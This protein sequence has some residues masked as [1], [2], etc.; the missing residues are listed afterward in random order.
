VGGWRGYQWEVLS[1]GMPLI[2]ALFD[3]RVLDDG[4]GPHLYANVRLRFHPGDWSIFKWDG[5]QWNRMPQGF[6][7]EP[8]VLGASFDDGTGLA[9]Y[10]SFYDWSVE[11]GTVERWT[12]SSW[13]PVGQTDRWAAEQYVVYD[14]GS[15]PSL[16]V[17]GPFNAIGGVPARRIARWDGAMWHALGAG[18]VGVR[19]CRKLAVIEDGPGAG[20]YFLG[21]V[22]VSSPN[23]LQKWDGQS[24]TVIPGPTGP[25]N[26]VFTATEMI[27]FDDGRGPAI[28]LGGSFPQIGGLQANGLARW[29]GVEWSL[30]GTGIGWGGVSSFGVFEDDPR[31]PSLFVIGPTIAGGGQVPGRLAQWVGCPNCYANCDSSQV[32]PRLNVDDFTCFINKFAARDPY[33]NCNSDAAIDV[34]DFM[35]FLGRFAAGC[36]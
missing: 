17:A 28:Y 6:D 34:Q 25:P 15:G 11:Q 4:H 23:Y 26:S 33:A 36:E 10:A 30:V 2:D 7:D 1:E 8:M 13:Q 24:W 18:P 20:L 14:D 9:I 12:G 22:S 31:G 27:A 21:V 29:D 3:V 32:S 16:Y 35:C 19:N 5:V